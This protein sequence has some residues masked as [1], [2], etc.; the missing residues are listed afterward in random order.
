MATKSLP[1]AELKYRPPTTAEWAAMGELTKFR[2]CEEYLKHR[3]LLTSRMAK[4]LLS[5][6]PQHEEA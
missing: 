2:A 5:K 4:W 1:K 6:F 3:R